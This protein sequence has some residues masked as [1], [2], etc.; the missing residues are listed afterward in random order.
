MSKKVLVPLQLPA[1][2]TQ[3]LEAAT[4]QYVDSQVGGGGPPSGTAGGDL[5]GNYPNPQIAAGVIVAGDL[6]LTSVRLNTI[7]SPN[8]N[9]AMGNNRITNLAYP[10][11]SSDAA[12]MKYVDDRLELQDWKAS[13]RVATTTNISLSGLPTLDGYTLNSGERVLVKDQTNSVEN[14]VYVSQAGSWSRAQDVFQSGELSGGTA[15]F[16][17]VGATQNSTGWWCTYPG[18]VTIGTTP[19]SWAKFAGGE[20]YK[21]TQMLAPVRTAGGSSTN[22]SPSGNQS[23]DGVTTVSGDRVLLVAQS[24]STDNGIW[25]SAAG[26][27]S[28]AADADSAV[29]VVQGTRVRVLEGNSNKGKTYTQLSATPGDSSGQKWRVQTSV[30]VGGAFVF[31]SP[32][33]TGHLYFNQN[34]QALNIWDGLS[35]VPASTPILCTAVTRPNFVADRTVIYETDTGNSFIWSS[36]SWRQFGGSGAE[37]NV[38][39][40]GPSPRAGELLWVDTDEPGGVV[41]GD[42]NSYSPTLY[43][44]M[45]AGSN[46][47]YGRYKL[48][49]SKTLLL[50]IWYNVGSGTSLPSQMI[51]GLPPGMVAN[52]A[53][54][55]SQSVPCRYY[56]SGST[57]ALGFASTSPGYGNGD[58][59]GLLQSNGAAL[60]G[61]LFVV[62]S[63]LDINGILELV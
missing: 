23:I 51:F 53:N 19:H 31:P 13:V 12:S 52:V 43:N 18:T 63:N 57:Q 33:N 38:S 36:G 56:T 27:W 28:R 46:P 35:W 41:V 3:P 7:G 6:D 9:V 25:V 5:T 49:D 47:V 30:D 48:L 44:G 40:A 15:V 58:R 62:G 39:I 21:D 45:V 4:K 61:G 60:P 42:W 29:E 11:S 59:I 37:V 26:A 55:R 50:H 32:M 17:E 1:D 2:P 54:T 10:S 22:Y 20:I 8:N 14:G 34:T 24:V 16:V